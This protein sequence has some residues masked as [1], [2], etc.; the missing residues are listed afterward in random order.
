MEAIL[1]DFGLATIITDSNTL[2][3]AGGTGIATA[4][5]ATDTVTVN[6][7]HLGIQDLSDPGSDKILIWDDSE[8]EVAWATAN[9]NLAISGTNINAT[10][11]TPT[12][13]KS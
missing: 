5:G 1:L 3:V 9:N 8:S 10:E 2:D 6:L 7:S 12:T 11:S 13:P 4:V